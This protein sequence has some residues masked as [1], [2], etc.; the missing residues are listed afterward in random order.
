MD[1]SK[2]K[3]LSTII[4]QILG[5]FCEIIDCRFIIEKHRGL[6]IKSPEI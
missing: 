3:D 6:S 1:F 5:V 2:V 4:F